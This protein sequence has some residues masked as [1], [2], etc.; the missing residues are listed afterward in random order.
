MVPDETSAGGTTGCFAGRDSDVEVA[1]AEHKDLAHRRRAE[2]AAAPS[3][4]A[5]ASA[6]M[7]NE[8]RVFKSERREGR[9]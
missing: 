9:L 2:A 8:R 4:E 1:L 5:R 6:A 7:R 3:Q